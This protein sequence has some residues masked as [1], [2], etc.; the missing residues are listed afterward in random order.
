MLGTTKVPRLYI[1]P[2]P[3]DL[4]KSFFGNVRNGLLGFGFWR[5]YLEIRWSQQFWI[6]TLKT[7]K[8]PS[9]LKVGRWTARPKAWSKPRQLWNAW[10]ARPRTAVGPKSLKRLSTSVAQDPNVIIINKSNGADLKLK[11]NWC[12][13][14]TVRRRQAAVEKAAMEKAAAEKA[15]AEK[16]A[17]ERAA[18]EKAAAE[19]AAAEKAA[20]EKAEAEVLPGV[21]VHEL[22]NRFWGKWHKKSIVSEPWQSTKI[23]WSKMHEQKIWINNM[24]SPSLYQFLH[25]KLFE[26]WPGQSWSRKGVENISQTWGC[27]TD[28]LDHWSNLVNQKMCFWMIL[29]HRPQKAMVKNM[30]VS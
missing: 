2:D 4:S 9:C 10:W 20:A 15:A 18:A 17:A 8:L 27:K 29:G 22:L 6:Q 12:E 16:A 1:I 11:V 24:I 19:K 28:G 3:F 13:D 26:L 5:W 30:L 25:T 23:L 7:S 21:P 14:S